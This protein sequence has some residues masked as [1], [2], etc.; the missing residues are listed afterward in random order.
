MKLFKQYL[1]QRR[2]GI[3]MALLFGVLFVITFILY[4]LPVKAVLYPMGLCA[5]FS[6]IFIFF[7]FLF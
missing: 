5:V 7:D 2:R 1:K 4:R 3:A 6:M